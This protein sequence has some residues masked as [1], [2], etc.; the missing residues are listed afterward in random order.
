[1][2]TTIPKYTFLNVEEMTIIFGASCLLGVLRYYVWEREL[3][4]TK[5]TRYFIRMQ[6]TG[7]LR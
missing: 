2:T 7:T 5:L 3:I 6:K 1:M 4:S